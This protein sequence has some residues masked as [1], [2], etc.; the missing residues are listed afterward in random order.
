MARQL[1][2]QESSY[3]SEVDSAL[4]GLPRKFRNSLLQTLTQNLAE[5]PP[6]D[7]H[8]E[9]TRD[10]G[11]PSSYADE[12]L[13]DADRAA[14]GNVARVRRRHR[15]RLVAVALT[16]VALVV[17]GVFG[18]RWW[19]TWQPTFL[20]STAAMY[21]G[22]DKPPYDTSAF[23]EQSNIYGDV[24]QIT[25][26]PGTRV[27]IMNSIGAS[28]SVILIGAELPTEG[29]GGMYRADSI[30]PWPRGPGGEWPTATVPWPITV[31]SD[32]DTVH[33]HMHLT[34]LCPTDR[35]SP[36]TSLVL[37]HFTVHYRALGRD[38]TAEIPL[39]EPLQIVMPR[40]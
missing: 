34:L 39:I 27:T 36:G 14:P 26:T 21:A 38:R 10:L 3:L 37:D 11:Q 1:T 32:T 17:A 9:L 16:I 13:A 8:R 2:A 40:G 29:I 6:C 15:T 23:T 19:V 7:S 12:L 33:L 35:W 25:C 4:R 5:R 31:D 20:T 28:P 30:Q 22:P 24:A 18:Y